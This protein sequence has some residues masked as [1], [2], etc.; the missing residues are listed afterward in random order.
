MVLEQIAN[1]S[2]ERNRLVGSSPTHGVSLA[3][4]H[5]SDLYTNLVAEAVKNQSDGSRGFVRKD[6]K[7]TC[8]LFT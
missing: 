3:S 4:V 2:V 6:V 1:L 5:A 7:I 8:T